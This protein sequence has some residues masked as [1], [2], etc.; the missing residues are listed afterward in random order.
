MPAPIRLLLPPPPIPLL[1]LAVLSKLSARS[2]EPT[3]A[4]VVVLRL[5]FGKSVWTSWGS[6]VVSKDVPPKTVCATGPSLERDEEDRL[7]DALPV[8]LGDVGDVPDV[9]NVPMSSS[10]V[11]A[12]ALAGAAG[13][14]EVVTVGKEEL[15]PPKAEV[16]PAGLVEPGAP[17]DGVEEKEEVVEEKVEEEEEEKEEEEDGKDDLDLPPKAEISTGA[18]PAL[19]LPPPTSNGAALALNLNEEVADFVEAD[20]LAEYSLPPPKVLP[21]KPPPKLPPKPPEPPASP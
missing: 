7:D 14:E 11:L 6:R 15:P 5:A 3:L 16:L 4:L 9:P 8:R 17:K 18:A 20:D 13:K 1:L 10:C 12:L 21:P 2:E 19:P